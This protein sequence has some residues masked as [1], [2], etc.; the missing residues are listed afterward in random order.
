[1]NP[2]PK[3]TMDELTEAVIAHESKQT[4]QVMNTPPILPSVKTVSTNKLSRLFFHIERN[5]G[6]PLK[7]LSTFDGLRDFFRENPEC[8]ADVE[9][10]LDWVE[11]MMNSQMWKATLDNLEGLPKDSCIITHIQSITTP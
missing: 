1:M 2:K 7:E 8:C 11:H 9:T 3:T 5:C 10:T 6:R 4:E